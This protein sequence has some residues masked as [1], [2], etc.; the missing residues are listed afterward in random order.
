MKIVLAVCRFIRCE[1]K[2]GE[3]EKKLFL[4]APYIKENS[5]IDLE[6]N[7]FCIDFKKVDMSF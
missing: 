4:K 6:Q 7:F 2:Q 5:A 1:E 3:K